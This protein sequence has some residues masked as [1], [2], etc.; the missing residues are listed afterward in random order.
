MA[1]RRNFTQYVYYNFI[2]I[3]T[4]ADALINL[5][6]HREADWIVEQAAK[7]GLFASFWQ[8]SKNNVR[9]VK[10]K[11]V[12]NLQESGIAPSLAKIKRYWR[13]IRHDALQILKS[14]K[15]TLDTEALGNNGKWYLYYLYAGGKKIRKNCANAEVTCRLLEDIPQISNCPQCSVLFSLMEAGTHVFSHSGPS[16]TKLRV[17]LGLDIPDSSANLSAAAI[18]RMRVCNEYLQWKQG[19]MTIFDDS[20]DHEVWHF[21]KYNYSRLVLIIDILHPN[22]RKNRIT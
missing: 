21:N 7:H 22:L 9:A 3:Y 4:Y 13:D 19:Q 20:F 15:Y 2:F 10:S 6:R 12:W 16:N 8:R 14:S 18:S 5:D 11:P 17:H 1:R